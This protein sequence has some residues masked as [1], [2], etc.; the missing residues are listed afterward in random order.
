M[1]CGNRSL[2]HSP[3]RTNCSLHMLGVQNIHHHNTQHTE[4]A[5]LFLY[6]AIP[7]LYFCFSSLFGSLSLSRSLSTSLPLSLS[8]SPSPKSQQPLNF[9]TEKKKKKKKPILKVKVFCTLFLL[10]THAHKDTDLSLNRIWIW[11]GPRPLSSNLSPPP[12][13]E[14]P[15]YSFLFNYLM[16]YRSSSMNVTLI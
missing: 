15:N 1:D 8:P 6:I 13:L 4:T 3:M 5:S 10:P 16:K 9:H 11:V 12:S 7:S 2:S 14:I